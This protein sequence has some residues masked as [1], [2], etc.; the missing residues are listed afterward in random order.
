[1]RRASSWLLP[2][3]TANFS[4]LHQVLAYSG[5]VPPPGMNFIR[6]LTHSVT[7][8]TYWLSL[9][10]KG[11]VRRIM[12]YST[13]SQIHINPVRLR[14]YRLYLIGICAGRAGT[15]PCPPW[16]PQLCRYYS[17]ESRELGAVSQPYPL[18]PGMKWPT[19]FRRGSDVRRGTRANPT[20]C[21]QLL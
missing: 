21:F 5:F 1:M 12:H 2:T 20:K 18:P 9:G 6:R 16:P 4:K 10:I 11:G 15:L 17:F 8:R 7:L 13:E 19:T 3:S 14:I